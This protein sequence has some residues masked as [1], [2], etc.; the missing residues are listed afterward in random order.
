M[1]PLPAH[2]KSG[3]S[4]ELEEELTTTTAKPTTVPIAKLTDETEILARCKNTFSAKLGKSSL[5]TLPSR[6]GVKPSLTHTLAERPLGDVFQMM[7]AV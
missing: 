3:K 4:A 5:G 2:L 1:F 7:Q 6:T